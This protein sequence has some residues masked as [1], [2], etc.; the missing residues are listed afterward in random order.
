[1]WT[2]FFITWSSTCFVM[3]LH[4]AIISLLIY[5]DFY[6][7]YPAQNVFILSHFCIFLT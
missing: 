6:K 1:M 2:V 3:T 5:S 4:S 7:I